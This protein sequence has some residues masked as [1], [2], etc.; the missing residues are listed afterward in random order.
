LGKTNK[1]YTFFLIT[2]LLIS[3]LASIYF[4]IELINNF[5][6]FSRDYLNFISVNN[7][8]KLPK[9]TFS[10]FVPVMIYPNAGTEKSTLSHNLPYPTI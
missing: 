5:E 9:V 10:I 1:I 3:S 7:D 4:T 6:H 8:K 2:V